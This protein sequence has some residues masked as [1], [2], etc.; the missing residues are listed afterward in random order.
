MGL[1]PEATAT[2]DLQV[3]VFVVPGDGDA[4][5][6]SARRQ[7]AAYLTVPVYTEFQRWLGRG[8]QLTDLLAAWNAGDRRK[9][10]PSL[11]R[12]Q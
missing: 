4:G 10:A 8:D 7:I 11:Q 5:E 3:R 1:R 2:P 6:L 9:A 12:F